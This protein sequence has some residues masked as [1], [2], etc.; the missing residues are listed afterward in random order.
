MKLRQLLALYGQAMRRFW[1]VAAVFVAAAALC[2]GLALKGK[3]SWARAVEKREDRGRVVRPLDY[4][5]TGLWKSAV[6]NTALLLALAATVPLWARRG[7]T[8]APPG[9]FP[10][11]TALPRPDRSMPRLVFWLGLLLILALGLG[12]RLPRM[13]LSIYN[14]EEHTLRT[15]TR[16]S[17]PRLTLETMLKYEQSKEGLPFRR[18]GWEWT[19]WSTTNGPNHVLF[20][21]LSRACLTVENILRGRPENAFSDGVF[22]IPS[23][24]GSLGMILFLGL[25]VS[26]ETGMGSSGWAVALLAATH[27][28]MIRYGTE[29]RGYG[30]MMFF[31]AL[32]WWFAL[33]GLRRPGWG[34]WVGFALAQWA[35]LVA[36]TGA[37]YV[38]LVLNLTLAPVML[39]PLWKEWRAGAGAR[40]LE[41]WHWRRFTRWV[42]A[43]L[44]TL[45]LYLPMILPLLPQYSAYFDT[46]FASAETPGNWFQDFASY[47]LAGVP[48]ETPPG[49][50]LPSV[51]YGLAEGEPYSAAAMVLVPLLA[52]AGA[53]LLLVRRG[54]LVWLIPTFALA[55]VIGYWHNISGGRILYIW[56]LIFAVPGVL[57][58]AGV[59]MSPRLWVRGAFANRPWIKWAVPVFISGLISVECYLPKAWLLHDRPKE[60]LE[61]AIR[62]SGRAVDPTGQTRM[63]SVHIA[64]WTNNPFYDPWAITVVGPE[65]VEEAIAYCL[66]TGRELELTF[67]HRPLI[68]HHMPEVL[69]LLED[70]GLFH[71]ATTMPGLEE[72]QFDIHVTQLRKLDPG[73][74][75]RSYHLTE[76]QRKKLFTAP[77]EAGAEGAFRA[78]LEGQGVALGPES[79]LRYFP[80]TGVMVLR[81][82]WA[83]HVK[84]R[85]GLGALR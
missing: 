52:L 37:V 78:W 22:R 65:T 56:Y 66:E 74:I 75:T 61:Q 63:P 3:E 50:D 69:E 58:L 85:K 9:S 68:E 10:P 5:K 79:M 28:W 21:I 73:K 42:V 55:P 53:I 35:L 13:D 32:L 59:G 62:L 82:A 45:G 27:P 31:C 16:G 40:L 12:L 51:L 1:I 80:E 44:V 57:V 83:E 84:V 23:L 15:Y 38:P 47:S 18:D 8:D 48:W 60:D 17:F 11:S 76:K 19:I 43:N 33:G 34:N 67:G 14:D 30:L 7:P 54:P 64:C 41:G 2:G 70:H 20:S 81:N 72:K 26:R 6:L 36:Y 29:G 77:H 71:P 49:T 39:W 25:L 4:M 24:L 46:E